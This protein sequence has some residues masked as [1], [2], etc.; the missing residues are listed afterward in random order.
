M[1]LETLLVCKGEEIF[2]LLILIIIVNVNISDALL[3]LLGECW[4][5]T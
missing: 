1:S 5:K 4:S 3:M 2:I